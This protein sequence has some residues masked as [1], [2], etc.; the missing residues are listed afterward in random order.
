[1]THNVRTFLVF[2]AL[3]GHSTKEKKK[4]KFSKEIILKIK[5]F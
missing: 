4:I 3:K 2:K 5:H 1:M